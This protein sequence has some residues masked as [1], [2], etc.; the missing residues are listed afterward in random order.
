MMD[1]PKLH[2]YIN[3]L[4]AYWDEMSLWVNSLEK[5]EISRIYNEEVKRNEG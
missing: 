2:D 4:P 3:N 1:M 5:G